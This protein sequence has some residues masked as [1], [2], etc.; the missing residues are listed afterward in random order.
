MR[1]ALLGSACAVAL[2]CTFAT[3]AVAEEAKPASPATI[4]AQRAVDVA[5]PA[6]DGRDAEFAARG[7]LGTRPDPLIEAADGH[8]VWNLAAYDF[9]TGPA[10]AT[11]N[12]SLWRHARLLARHGLFAVADGVWQV[13]GFDVSNM[14]VVKG[15]TGWIL[16][17]PLTAR[18][19]AAAALELVNSS[20]GQRP[21]SAV[22][23]SHSHGDHYGGVR[24][25]IDE[26]DV[27]AGK[28][29]VLAP[30]GFVEE[31]ASESVMAGAAMGRRATF[32][33]GMGLAPGPQGQMS[34]GIG[35][36]LPQGE[37]TLI[38]PTDIIAKTGEKRTVDGVPLEFQIVSGSE[39]PAELNVY[40]ARPKVF[41]SAEISTCSLHNILTPRGAKVRDAHAWA[42]FLD[43]ALRLYAPRSEALI[44]SHCWPRFGSGEVA[45][46]LA[47]HRDNYRYL[48]DQTVRAMNAGA[49]M[50]EIAETVIQ[51]AQIAAHWYDR[52]YYGTYRHNSK[53]IY[54]YYLGWYDAV[55]AHLDPHPPTERARKY[56]AA[57]GGGKAVLNLARK[58]MAAGDYRWSSDLLDK[59]VFADPANAAA[60]ALL[61]DS[62]EQQGYQAESAI[63]RNQFLSAARELRGGG[64][65][66]SPRSQS[67]EMIAAIPTQL[68][69]DSAATRFAPERADGRRIA[70]NLA[71]TDRKER[72]GIEAGP[73]TLIARMTPLADAAATLTGPR[74][75]FLG[76][77][78]AKAPLAQLEAAGLKIE[79]DR[80]A[81]EALANA[82]DP[83]PGPFPIAE[84]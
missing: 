81:V 67:A 9:V 75:L 12:P 39:A 65:T 60:R 32:Q 42:G 64:A 44:S 34:S 36:A 83:L 3:A 22:I 43:E 6:D 8:T 76:L 2:A 61:A 19:T 49:T 84:P 38:A 18:E 62:Y 27:A 51:P 20:L 7:F 82:L 59:L 29:A 11:V 55:P 14:T 13:R 50:D 21:V 17:D 53:A 57:M 25:V 40:I 33:F 69:L 28:V 73:S 4:A 54:Q 47:A 10:P 58:A 23:Y 68:L 79:G 24:G 52:G 26:K 5:L 63:W 66:A 78:F 70:V 71:I 31:S 15:R 46:T 37:I 30:A 48:H 56:V 41:L 45:E 35:P 1:P 77:F 16:I 80:A 72:V 74:P